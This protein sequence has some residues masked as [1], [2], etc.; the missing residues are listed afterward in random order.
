MS[1]T[2]AT[3]F[4]AGG[5]ACG[6]KADG[7]A[8]LALITAA[9]PV[10]TAAV[11]TRNTAAAPPVL[12]SRDHVANGRVQSVVINSGCANAATG[13][14]GKAAALAMAEAAAS[15]LGCHPTE[16]LVCSTGPIGGVVPVDRIAPALVTM[17]LTDDGGSAAAAA[18]LTTDT[19]IKE[20]VATA[21]GFTVGGMAKGAGMIRPDMAT[22]LAV[23]TTD[24][25]AEAEVLE[26]VL[27]RAVGLSFNALNIDGCESTND[28]AVLMASGAS[29]I[30]PEPVA[31]AAAVEAVCRSL[32]RQMA[33]D[34]E[35]AS[36]VVT[37]ELAGAAEDNT[38]LRLARA[39]ADSA[40]VRAS[41]Y[42]GD[43]NWGR[44]VAALGA[45]KLPI[46]PDRLAVAYAG[47]AVAEEGRA[48]G[49]DPGAVAEKLTGDFTVSITVGSG[50]GSCSLLTN[51]L[52]PDY[53]MFNGARS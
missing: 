51:D 17:D 44:V 3:G 50:P 16:V 47:V 38:A 14:A 30:R 27:A 22:M 15:R 10:P 8:D 24:A 31:L 48:T 6:I 53:V 46:E 5:A 52:T 9:N 12:L 39:V 18:I 33:E 35:G 43:P 40:L 36:R 1:V 4:L 29:E 7:S 26:T 13:V 25:V 20:A 32:A 28:T 2:A 34:A 11:F 41:F 42:G 23:I 45:A 21:A 49:A 19:C 37:I